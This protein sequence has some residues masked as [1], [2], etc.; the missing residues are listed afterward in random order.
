MATGE[1]VI[2][3]GVEVKTNG[4]GIVGAMSQYVMGEDFTIYIERFGQYCIANDVKDKKI[5]VAML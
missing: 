5:M 1:Q 2:R 3:N 4:S